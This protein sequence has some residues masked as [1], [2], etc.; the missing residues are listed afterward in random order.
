[1]KI[2]YL[3][4]PCALALGLGLVLALLWLLDGG[5][6]LAAVLPAP[7]EGRGPSSC[8]LRASSGVITVCLSGGCDYTSIQDAVDAADEGDVIKVA[9]GIYTDVH[10][11]PSPGGSDYGHGGG[12]DVIT[13][14]VYISKTVTIRGGYTGAFTEPPDPES[15]P[16]TLDAQGRGRVL[17]ITQGASATVEGLRV[18]GG[19]AT[20]LGG[21]LEPWIE[22][23]SDAGGGIYVSGA[24]A[25]LRHNWVFSNAAGGGGGLYLGWNDTIS[26]S[27]NV[28]TSNTADY[29]GGLYVDFSDATL[30]D[31]VITANS[32]GTDGGGLYFFNSDGTFS[33]NT[34]KRNSADGYG[35]GMM[36]WGHD[37]TLGGNTVSA[38]SAGEYGGGMFLLGS[39]ATLTNNVVADNQA[40]SAGSGLLVMNCSPRLT[41]NT[42]ARN[43]RGDGS[44]I[45]IWKVPSMY[46]PT[47]V[48]LTNNILVSH[49]VG[50]TATVD[51][52]AILEATLWGSGSWANGA[53]WG[54]AGTIITG[55]P[56]YNT[57]GDPDFVDP[58]SGDYHIGPGSAA[59]D[60]GVDAGVTLDMDGEPRPVGEGYDLGADEFPVVPPNQAPYIPSDPTPADGAKDVSLNR[61][62]SWRGGDPD[63]DPVT[64]TVAFGAS[65]PPP[66]V[67]TTILTGYTPTL[68]TDIAY[69][70]AITA[71]D[72]ISTSAGPTWHFSTVGWEHVYL[73]LVLRQ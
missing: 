34:V 22:V 21:Y 37:G 66:V 64:Y 55:T 28:V 52:T 67:G 40:D 19:V 63:G 51:S 45:Y 42:I 6:A 18:T 14:V 13:Q 30:W 65:D 44:G 69:Y 61:T 71:T 54:G 35:G 17:L 16:A 25:T 41:H 46:G 29:G 10:R 50:I 33:G 53:D 24:G 36:L 48:A 11:R 47:S 43:S 56:A 15:N 38:N 4:V 72:G 68:I 8:P 20:G 58:D 32:A 12:P 1:M 62:L 2:R 23:P 5:I 9:A 3:L 31:N 60:R 39:D 26:V 70:W 49:T 7:G 57:W 59:I 73:P 27:G